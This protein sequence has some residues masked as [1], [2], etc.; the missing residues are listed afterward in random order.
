MTDKGFVLEIED[1]VVPAVGDDDVDG[2]E[3]G[4]EETGNVEF[5]DGIFKC[6]LK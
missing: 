4:D 6:V 1:K 5:D 2:L 3:S